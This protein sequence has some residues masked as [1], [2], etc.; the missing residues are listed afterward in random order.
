MRILCLCSI[1]TYEDDGCNTV[2]DITNDS[3]FAD[4]NGEDAADFIH[5]DRQ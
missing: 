4:D 2:L 1:P 3:Q 5:W